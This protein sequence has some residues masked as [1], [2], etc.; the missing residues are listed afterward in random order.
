MSFV[1]CFFSLLVITAYLLSGEIAW[2]ASPI[3]TYDYI[4]IREGSSNYKVVL[5]LISTTAPYDAVLFTSSDN[6][7]A[8]KTKMGRQF[9]HIH[10]NFS[11][12]KTGVIKNTITPKTV[13][14]ANIRTLW[15]WKYEGYTRTG[16]EDITRNC[17]GY[18][19]GVNTWVNNT[20]ELDQDNLVSVTGWCD[21]EI[22]RNGNTHSI[23]VDKSAT[24]SGTF[25]YTVKTTEKNGES[26]IY[27]RTWGWSNPTGASDK[28]K[29]KP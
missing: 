8:H 13:T 9:E 19:F 24:I 23:L 16:S 18:A 25:G 27:E 20:T 3:L 15:D 26:A 5:T 7:A 11:L 2:C 17:H 12:P 14:T 29:F 1:K 28:Y 10:V 6:C 21:T 4:E 22:L